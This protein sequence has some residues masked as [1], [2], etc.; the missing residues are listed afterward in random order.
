MWGEAD[1]GAVERQ[2]EIGLDGD[3]GDEIRVLV[4]TARVAAMARSTVLW[5]W[6]RRREDLDGLLDRLL[7]LGITPQEVHQAPGRQGTDQHPYCEVRI[8]G[9][10][11]EATLQYL[12]WSHQIAQTTVVVLRATQEALGSALAR[13]A[14]VARLDYVLAL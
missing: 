10:F 5:S 6:P 12:G 8:G 7:E 3:V 2:Y 13:M 14:A 9:C 1:H 4:P 11:G